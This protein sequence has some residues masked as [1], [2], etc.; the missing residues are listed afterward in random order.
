MSLRD[1]QITELGDE[2]YTLLRARRTRAPLTSAFPAIEIDDAYKISL[3]LLERRKADGERIIGKK[4]GVTSKPVQEMLGV[5][6][7]D[8]GFLLDRM[9]VA[10][11]S[12]VSL[13][14]HQLIQP[15]AEGEIAFVLAK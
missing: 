9:Q 15:R 3:R 4:I 11:A 13:S 14:K 5:H 7:P 8:F 6:Q 2:L 1:D 12:T 10:D